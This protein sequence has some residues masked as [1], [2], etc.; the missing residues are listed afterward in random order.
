MTRFAVLGAIIVWSATGFALAAPPQHGG[1]GAPHVGGGGAPHVGGGGAPHFGGGGGAPHVG[2]GGAPHFAAPQI[3]ASPHIAAP[4]IAHAPSFARSLARPSF[5]ARTVHSVVRPTFRGRPVARP[6]FATRRDV[7]HALSRATFR[8]HYNRS[9]A[10]RVGPRNGRHVSL[11]ANRNRATSLR[12]NA[13]LSRNRNRRNSSV[14]GNRQIRNAALNGNRTNRIA[15]INAGN[16]A[17]RSALNARPVRNAL[18][19]P[20]ELRNPTTRSMI[21][22]SAATAAWRHGD[23]DHDRGWWRH[24]HG[25]Y[26]WVGPLFWPFAYYDVYDYALWGPDY[27]NS[28][29]DYG[30]GDIYAGLFAPY[31]Y[32]D[33]EGYLPEYAE[34]I[35]SGYN[36]GYGASY[37]SRTIGTSS[38]TKASMSSGA[39]TQMCGEDTRDIAG[40]PIDQIQ[41]SLQLDKEQSAALGQLADASTKAAQIIRAACPTEIALTAPGRLE[42][43]QT[44]IEAML[45]AV[46]VIQPPLDKLY[47]LLSDEQKA[48]L[49]ALG[50]EQ[51]RGNAA[52]GS[53]AQNCGAPQP[54]V[55]DWPAAEINRAVRPT[56]AQRAKLDALKDATAH[57]AEMLKASCPATTP[58]TPPARLAAITKRLDTMQQAI[59]TIRIALNG[60]YNSLSDEQ[61]AQFD[62]IGPQ[63]E[64][65]G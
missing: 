59:K 1:G 9:L 7:A 39:L 19:D 8:G 23:H 22:A 35:S 6:N 34:G 24:R 40:L 60:F 61:K 5:S 51:N 44:R 53:V 18:R 56:E 2:G 42:A 25:G 64:A 16:R 21:T 63:R 58:L 33:L 14:I 41:Q 43:M 31:S 27:D 3:S 13:S 30:Y 52:T 65:G 10:R 62:A 15:H 11:S 26:G 57:A 29:W 49:N 54:G 48:R 28:F 12:R 4:S 50:Q 45:Q 46:Q 47:G 17:I 36:G 32:D 20:R 37:A 38:R 55:T